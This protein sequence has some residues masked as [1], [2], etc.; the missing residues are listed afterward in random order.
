MD[1]ACVVGHNPREVRP[2]AHGCHEVQGIEETKAKRDEPAGAIEHLGVD[3]Y[4]VAVGEQP[5]GAW[6][7]SAACSVGGSAQLGAMQIRDDAA[8]A[9]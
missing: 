7:C 5:L 6:E 9:P 3:P 4:D 2:K 8:P 1:Q